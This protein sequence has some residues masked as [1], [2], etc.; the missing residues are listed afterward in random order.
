MDR[1]DQLP[2]LDPSELDEICD[3]DESL[4]GQLATMFRDQA[5]SAITEL[6]SAIAVGDA[7]VI[8]RTAHALKGSAAILGAKRLSA[9]SSELY[10][11]AAGD[12]LADA[13]R[14]LTALRHVY[15][16]TSVAMGADGAGTPGP[17]STA[18]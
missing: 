12:Q 8:Q 11:C 6:T 18:G 5:R 16:L 3:G 14:R 13:P 7:T 9:V 1:S 2:I 15:D 17:S 4:R 10:E